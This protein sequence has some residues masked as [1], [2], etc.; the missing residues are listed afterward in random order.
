VDL[1]K[2]VESGPE[3]ENTAIVVTYDEHGGFWDHVPH[4]RLPFLSDQWGPGERVPTL[5]ISQLFHESG[6]L[7]QTLDTTSILALIERRWG[8]LVL[9]TRDGAYFSAMP[10]L[11]LSDLLAGLG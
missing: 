8:V 4:T 5:F 7:H 6:V 1:I 10:P 11:F 3:A 9:G 2:A